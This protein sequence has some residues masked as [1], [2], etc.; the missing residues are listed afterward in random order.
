MIMLKKQMEGK[1]S[2]VVLMLT[3]LISCLICISINAFALNFENLEGIEVATGNTVF[4]MG[5]T[6]SG[7]IYVV[8]GSGN[9]INIIGFNKSSGRVIYRK[10]YIGYVE[11]NNMSLVSFKNRNYYYFYYQ[12]SWSGYIAKVN[13]DTGEITTTPTSNSTNY[14]YAISNNGNIYR[15]SLNNSSCVIEKYNGLSWTSFKTVTG[16]SYCDFNEICIPNDDIIY[17]GYRDSSGRSKIKKVNVSNSSETLIFSLTSNSMITLMTPGINTNDLFFAYKLNNKNGAG[18]C[19]YKN[20]TNNYKELGGGCNLG[21]LYDNPNHCRCFNIIFLPGVTDKVCIGCINRNNGSYP[22]N[23]FVIMSVDGTGNI[24]ETYGPTSAVETI[25]EDVVITDIPNNYTM[26]YSTVY[27]VLGGFGTGIN[28]IW[29]VTSKKHIRQYNSTTETT[30]VYTML[31][32]ISSGYWIRNSSATATLS[33]ADSQKL[34]NIDNNT[35][36]GSTESVANIANEVRSILRSGDGYNGKS[37]AATYDK[38]VAAGGTAS[39]PQTD[40]TAIANAVGNNSTIQSIKTNT[41]EARNALRKAAIKVVD[42]VSF[43]EVVYDE[44]NNA[45]ASGVTATPSVAG[46]GY[47]VITGTLTGTGIKVVE[48]TS[49]TDGQSRGIIFNVI[50]KPT[51]NT[52][53]TAV[54]N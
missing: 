33:T 38:A 22:T 10:A 11:V 26:Q 14:K 18:L 25:V 52:T 40:I 19:M 44:L 17:I 9:S 24:L 13:L 20:S 45:T 48:F 47:S 36:F 15:G 41:S 39:L 43:T 42:G 7:A 37:L 23:G 5:E 31:S 35:K 34:T 32:P 51:L 50:A 2:K 8:S 21:A 30:L 28:D 12:P 4:Q 29:V 3:I 54:F 53:A 46:M 1:G 6:D 49:K 27:E 16:F